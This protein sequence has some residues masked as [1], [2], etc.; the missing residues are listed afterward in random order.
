MAKKRKHSARVLQILK[1]ALGEMERAVHA[2]SQ[3]LP[4]EE[5]GGGMGNVPSYSWESRSIIL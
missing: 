4:L 2:I 1:S 5:D 3:L